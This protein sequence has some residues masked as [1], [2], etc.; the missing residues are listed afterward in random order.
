[1]N[2]KGN[3]TQARMSRILAD[4]KPLCEL[5]REW[6]EASKLTPAEAARQ[7]QVSAQLWWQL[8]HGETN[9]PRGAT[10]VKLCRGT[11]IPMERLAAASYVQAVPA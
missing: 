9:N 7:C 8:E 11:G 2:F 10:M 3:L 5:L 6:R 1:M 4:M